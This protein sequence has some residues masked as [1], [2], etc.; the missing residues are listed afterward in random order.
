MFAA[1]E[2]VY[3]KNG[4]AT[5]DGSGDAKLIIACG[6]VVSDAD[7]EKLGLRALFTPAKPTNKPASILTDEK[8]DTT[9]AAK[10]A[11]AG[12]VGVGEGTGQVGP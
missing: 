1:P 12:V 4:K 6:A 3:L 7:V 11:P 5:L 9:K 2:N 10:T 8:P